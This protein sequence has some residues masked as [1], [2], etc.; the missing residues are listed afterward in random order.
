MDAPPREQRARAAFFR[1]KEAR[2]VAKKQRKKERLLAKVAQSALYS[3]AAP[4]TPQSCSS[5]K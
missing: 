4:P 3:D 2:R 5:G 1:E